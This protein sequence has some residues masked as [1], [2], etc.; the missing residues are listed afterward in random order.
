MIISIKQKKPG[1]PVRTNPHKAFL[2]FIMK[3]TALKGVQLHAA[4]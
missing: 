2:A 4:H 3:P 1:K